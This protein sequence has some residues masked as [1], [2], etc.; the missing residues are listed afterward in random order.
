[1]KVINDLEAK[2]ILINEKTAFRVDWMPFGGKKLSG[3]AS[4][5]MLYSMLDLTDEKLVVIKDESLFE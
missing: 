3:H 2:A 4:A 5:G 1:M